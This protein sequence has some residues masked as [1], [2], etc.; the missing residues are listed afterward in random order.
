[1]GA[2]AGMGA[3]DVNLT[4][5]SPWELQSVTLHRGGKWLV[6]RCY[7]PLGET[8]PYRRAHGYGPQDPPDQPS[9]REGWSVKLGRPGIGFGDELLALGMVQGLTEASGDVDLVY[10]GSRPKLMTRCTLPMKVQFRAGLGSVETAGSRRPAQFSADPWQATVTWL[11]LVDEEQVEVH[12]ALPMR[13]YLDIEMRT[14]HR[15]KAA[16]N[17]MPRFLSAVPKSEPLHAT[18][19]MASS[20]PE[21]KSYGADNFALVAR[22]LARR[23]NKWPTITVITAKGAPADASAPL[24]ELGAD[25]LDDLTAEECIDVFASSDLVIGNDTGLT[26]LAALTIRKDGSGPQVV[27][28][29]STFSYSKYTTGSPTHHAVATPFSQMLTLSNRCYSQDQVSP[30]LW[31]RSAILRDISP[32]VVAEFAG[33][34]AGWW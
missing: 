15:L 11:D 20:D 3:L 28:L 19:I 21:I 10:S 16:R 23:L 24:R 26:H 4:P 2:Q 8:L 6:P 1:M 5:A 9:L 33:E 27:S 12:A 34:R 7:S 32:I 13:F 30:D 31:G 29:Y 17:P 14:G 25:V 22:E 18:F